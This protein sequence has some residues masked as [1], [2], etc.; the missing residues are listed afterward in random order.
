MNRFLLVFFSVLCSQ[1]VFSQITKQETDLVRLNYYGSI[2]S[3]FQQT[4]D[5]IDSNGVIVKGDLSNEYE[6]RTSLHL[7]GSDG[8][9]IEGT[10]FK[11]KDT[12]IDNRFIRIDNPDS[13]SISKMSFLNNN[14][15]P[16]YQTIEYYN[17]DGMIDSIIRIDKEYISKKYFKYGTIGCVKYTFSWK[18]ADWNKGSSEHVTEHKYI[19]NRRGN[20]VKEKINNEHTKGFKTSKSLLYRDDEL[21]EIRQKEQIISFDYDDTLCKSMTTKL[22]GEIQEIELYKYNTKGNLIWKQIS[23]VE[24]FQKHYRSPVSIEESW[25]Y[26]SFGNI[27]ENV[28]IQFINK[29]EIQRI[30]Y[31]YEY[32]YD[33]YNNWVKR[34]DYYNSKPIRI[35][36]RDLQYF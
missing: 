6:Y 22:N 1:L 31:S 15:R 26:D 16:D 12:V 14:S 33:D 27:L 4:Y 19:Y 34:I 28:K 21:I 13:S 11:S 17:S 36:E 32:N 3:V 7:F 8:N 24:A 29:N 35:I 5:A 18:Y 2:K 25:S 10:A 9:I 30:D 20:L 23:D